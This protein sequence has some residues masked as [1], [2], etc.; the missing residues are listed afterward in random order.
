[1]ASFHLGLAGAQPRGLP[2]VPGSL[3][4]TRDGPNGRL[5]SEPQ[6]G[7]DDNYPQQRVGD[8]GVAVGA[9]IAGGVDPYQRGGG[10]AQ[11]DP[12]ADAGRLDP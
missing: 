6:P 7:P 10:D 5:R 9:A 11:E 1:M 3:S 2:R 12:G 4:G 8:P